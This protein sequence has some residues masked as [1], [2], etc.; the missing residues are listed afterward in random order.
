MPRSHLG[1]LSVLPP[2]LIDMV[3]ESLALPLH[4]TRLAAS[5][6]ILAHQGFL[7]LVK[8]RSDLWEQTTWYRC[9]IVC[10]GD[11]LERA[12]DVVGL[13]P[14]DLCKDLSEAKGGERSEVEGQPMTL[15]QFA[16]ERFGGVDTHYRGPLAILERME[17]EGRAE[18]WRTSYLADT[19]R[20]RKSTNLLDVQ[21]IDELE[22][23]TWPSLPSA[24]T[25]V[26]C[27]LS[28]RQLVRAESLREVKMRP[29]DDDG[30]DDPGYY[31]GYA[32]YLTI[33]AAVMF[34]TVSTDDWSFVPWLGPDYSAEAKGVLGS[35]AGDSLAIVRPEDV[36]ENI[37]DI[38][39][40][41][42]AMVRKFRIAEGEY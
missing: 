5:H 1:Q 41:V 28:K 18:E 37:I 38:S 2:E 7:R 39:S 32:K 3:F 14:D 21:R 20:A 34:L 36:E 16:E 6:P 9:Q 42:A 4:I 25:S 33:G 24:D 27:S 12:Q 11:Y 23:Y 26:L 30:P 35:W 13:L 31:D 10:V 19:A 22:E 8:F 40:E 17:T 15:S 29:D